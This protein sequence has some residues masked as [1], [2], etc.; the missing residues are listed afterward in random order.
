MKEQFK[1]E[2]YEAYKDFKSGLI[3]YIDGYF[4]FYVKEKPSNGHSVKMMEF[5]VTENKSD[6]GG[7]CYSEN[8]K[9]ENAK[10][11]SWIS[12]TFENET[13]LKER[14][15]FWG[16]KIVEEDFEINYNI[17][18]KFGQENL[19]KVL[20]TAFNI[21]LWEESKNSE[22]ERKIRKKEADE[23]FE[24]LEGKQEVLKTDREIEFDKAKDEFFKYLTLENG[25]EIIE[26]LTTNNGVR[27]FVYTATFKAPDTLQLMP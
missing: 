11:S 24:K 6:F 2:I 7:Y 5:I 9:E 22:I 8:F 23:F 19:Y 18:I 20:S 15:N 3:K 14:K 21:C 4:I 10:I 16:K 13:I 25:G 27:E 12:W 26:H 17:K 1:E